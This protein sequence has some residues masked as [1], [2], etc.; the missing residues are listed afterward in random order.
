MTIQCP[1]CGTKNPDTK[2]FCGEC[3]TQLS[4]LKDIGPT[5][6]AETPKQ[7]LTTGVTFADRYQIIEGLGQGG[8]GRVY[9]ALDKETQEKI[10]LKLIKSEIAS[11]Q[12]TVGAVSERTDIS[13]QD[14][15]PPCLPHV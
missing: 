3:G 15:S 5:Q 9:K 14:I 6:T 1:N 11:D 13:P 7:E 4:S 8:M 10:A 2:K 12:K